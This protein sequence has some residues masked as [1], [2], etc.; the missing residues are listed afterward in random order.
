ML[1]VFL[2]E[3]YIFFTHQKSFGELINYGLTLPEFAFTDSI[4][5]DLWE[6]IQ[7]RLKIFP[8]TIDH[9]NTLLH[10]FHPQITKTMLSVFI[11]QENLPVSDKDKEYFNVLFLLLTQPQHLKRYSKLKGRLIRVLE[12]ET[13]NYRI[14]QTDHP[15][16]VH[17]ILTDAEV[18][19]LDLPY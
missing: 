1:S 18:K 2:K 5:H 4:R 17:H 12:D 16:I 3:S 15:S 10:L 7:E 19:L 6:L 8:S 14:R 13:I 9:H 11:N